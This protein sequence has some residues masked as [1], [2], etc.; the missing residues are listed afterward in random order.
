MPNWC[1]TQYRIKGDTNEVQDLH[2]AI[3]ALSEMKEPLVE[4]GF[5]PLWLGCLV[6]YLGEDWHNIPC[7]G[8]ILNVSLK[9]DV[10]SFDTET[11][12]YRC[13][14]VEQFLQSKFPSISIWFCTEEPGMEIYE[15][16]DKDEEFFKKRYIL[17]EINEGVEYYTFPE[18]QEQL[19]KKFGIVF[20]SY[21][22]ARDYLSKHNEEEEENE[23]SPD[24][25]YLYRFEF[26]DL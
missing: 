10:L 23:K 26:T 19:K 24:V 6:A 2:R 13:T 25:F 4:N 14:E 17:D 8:E 22:E 7:R 11:A 21:E 16:N 12:W 9:E 3:K 15:T 5:G 1:Y 20:Q 18:L